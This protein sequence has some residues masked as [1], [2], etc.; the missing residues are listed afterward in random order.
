M[1][2][3]IV[4]PN[5]GFDAQTGRLVEWLK[6]P[7]E[8]V[9]KGEVIAIVESDKANVELESIAGGI[10]LEHLASAD[11]EVAV[12]AVIAR[13]GAPNEMPASQTVEVNV[14]IAPAKAQQMTHTD[15]PLGDG[16]V[17]VSPVAR[18]IAE[19]NKLDLSRI[20]G[21]GTR[22]RITREDVLAALGGNSGNGHGEILAL[23]KVRRAARDA[24]IDLAE[25]P[26]SGR[27]GQ[28]T[29]ADLLAYQHSRE[30]VPPTPA[31]ATAPQ[32]IMEGIREIAISKMRQLIGDRLGKS[33][34][35]AP[36]FYVTGEF[37]LEIALRKLDS[38]PSPQPR[39]NDLL[40][41]L[42]VQTLLHVPELNAT[43]EEGHLYQHDSV[44][45]AVAV[46]RED[47]LITPVIPQAERYSLQGLAAESR[48]LIQRARD[49]RLQSSD[50]QG[51][52]F[53]I[54]NLGVI[55]QVDHF[56]AVI[57]PPQVAIL[58]VGTVKPRPVVV[59]GGLYIRQT[60][61]MTL[62]GDHRVVDGMHLGRFMATFQEE[63]DRF[64]R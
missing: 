2:T 5:M 27:Q 35:E 37:D 46:A 33:K 40:Q 63:L 25:V 43:Y 21:T 8:T 45:L 31:P 4:M 36:H 54:S 41:Y 47:G 23:P 6:Q 49:N 55:R 52:S 42:T 56:T 59:D 26:A 9:Q 28:I 44:N 11:S 62:S 22:G 1:A 14:S 20:K 18:R 32:R 64:I 39:V 50:L 13:V 34:R 10:L 16:M 24:G 53:T 60:V 7:G 12:G 17:E 48:A 19:E 38:L 57:N 29:L 3:D 15:T 61:H 58:A 30:T 51:G